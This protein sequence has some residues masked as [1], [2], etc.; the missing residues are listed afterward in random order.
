MNYGFPR[1]DHLKSKNKDNTFNYLTNIK[2]KNPKIILYTP[3]WRPYD[4]DFPLNYMPGMDYSKFQKF[5][6]KKN[7]Y[8]FYSQHS[9]QDF[10]NKPSNYS[11]IIGIN[12]LKYP[13]YDPT[14]FMKSVKILVNDYSATSTD[15]S[16]LKKPQL[17]YF[18]DFKKYNDYKGFLE[19]YK[20]N[21]IGF[22]IQNYNS[23]IKYIEACMKNK[24]FYLKKFDEKINNYQVKYYKKSN[25]NSCELFKKFIKKI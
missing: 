5:L 7:M 15:F 4:I 17:F 1:I 24:N 3:T 23:F 25:N 12:H 6:I 20:K 21:L 9:I 8:F 18:P 2:S 13:F 14:S 11:R 19:N 10:K 22:E 16:I